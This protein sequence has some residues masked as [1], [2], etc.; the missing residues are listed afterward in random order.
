MTNG[1]LLKAV[2]ANGY[3]VFVTTDKSIPFQH[4][5][6]G[7]TFA[8]VVPANWPQVEQRLSLVRRA[9]DQTPPGECVV[10][11]E[12]E[13]HAPRPKKGGPEL[14]DCKP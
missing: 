3:D 11:S 5:L 10:V 9:I 8:V 13:I 1:K 6:A 7:A 14:S 4:K 2:E 12:T